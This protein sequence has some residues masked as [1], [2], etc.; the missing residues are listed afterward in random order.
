MKA[1]IPTVAISRTVQAVAT[2]GVVAPTTSSEATKPTVA[3][4]PSYVAEGNEVFS[5]FFRELAE[6]QEASAHVNFPIAREWDHNS[7][8]RFFNLVDWEAKG[9]LTAAE[10]DELGG[11]TD[12]R[13]RF[14]APRTGREV[15]REYEQHQLIRNLLQSLTRYVE[16]VG[17]TTSQ[18]RPKKHRS[19]TKA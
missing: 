16:F 9:E 19:N 14:E 15:L 2:F 17:S 13:Q 10:L 8:R 18:P 12:L 5:G 4:D 6:E 3:A 1:R 7:E 11:L